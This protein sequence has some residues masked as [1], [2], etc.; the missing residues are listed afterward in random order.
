M[1]DPQNR[2]TDFNLP[3][4]VVWFIELSLVGRLPIGAPL[5]TKPIGF[6]FRIGD[7]SGFAMSMAPNA[8]GASRIGALAPALGLCLA[9]A[10][11][12][13]AKAPSASAPPQPAE[14]TEAGYL[15]PPQL[16]SAARAGTVLRLSGQAPA[17]ATVRF[18]S[19]DGQAFAATAGAGGTWSLDLPGSAQPRMFA[20][21]AETGGHVLRSEGA[22]IAAPAPAFPLLLAR[23]GA[24][25]LPAGD[26]AG[27]PALV[28]LDY[29]SGGGVSVG[30]FAAPGAAIRLTVD[31]VQVGQG[32]ADARGRFGVAVTGGQV[33]PGAHAFAVQTP[34]GTAGARIV[35]SAAAPLVAPFRAARE[36][37][38]WRIDWAPPGGGAQTTVLFDLRTMGS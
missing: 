24:A 17:G 37:G 18:A 4:G 28:S 30:G 36:A 11:C 32:Q 19:P 31:G 29:D 8:K 12:G 16:L 33:R 14:A 27:A 34:A 10:A 22:V 2:Q 9:L 15:A 13:P 35:L 26:G 1:D 3:V 7:A 5:V 23:A 21:S 20:L 6:G 25:A 38:G